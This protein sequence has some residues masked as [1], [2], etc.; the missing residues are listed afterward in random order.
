VA[1]KA[2][3]Y[4]LVCPIEGKVRYVGK[5]GNPVQRYMGHLSEAES[6]RQSEERARCEGLTLRAPR[7]DKQ[8]W[9][10]A[11]DADGLEPE[12]AIF[13][14]V[15]GSEEALAQAEQRW[16]DCFRSQGH[17]LLNKRDPV[18]PPELQERLMAEAMDRGHKLAEAL[19]VEPREA[20][21]A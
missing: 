3:I 10:L 18:K 19:G 21:L 20:P 12:L 6:R 14:E 13:E 7:T 11:L 5:S 9:L 17:P 2:Y 8:E 15:E 4:G 16:I 1:V